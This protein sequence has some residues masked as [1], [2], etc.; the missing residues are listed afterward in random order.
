MASYALVDINNFY[1]SAERVFNPKLN[2]VPTTAVSNNDG[3]CISRSNEAKAPPY[4][5]KMGE[6]LFKIIQRFKPGEI[7]IVSSNYALYADLSDRVAHI[8]SMFSSSYEVYSVDEMFLD[9]TGLERMGLTH[10]GYE[11]KDTILKWT[12]LPVCVGIAATKTM[13]KL[14]NRVAKKRPEFNGVCNFKEMSTKSVDDIMASLPVDE[15]WGIGH[16][17]STKLNQL[18]IRTVLDLKNAHTRTMREKFSVVVAKTISELRGESCIDLEEQPPAKQNIA[19]TRSFG[20]PATDL[21]SLKESVTLYTSQAAEK[22]RKQGSYA[23]SIT[24]FIQTSPF[25]NRPY[26]GNSQT[27]ALPSPSNDTRLLV[28]TALWILNRLYRPGHVYQK[29]GVMLND[30]VPAAGV[31]QDMF[32]GQAISTMKSEKVMAVLDAVNQRY[33]RQ[34]L[35]LASEGFKAPWQM[36]QEFKT[37]DYTCDWDGLIKAY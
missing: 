10:Y 16:R 7:H 27:V 19:S 34:T 14:S 9:W 15:V 35:K 24:V 3:C 26:Y 12:G 23:N 1:V 32:F 20:I 28:R 22:A 37:P 29:S 17:L 6:P 25:A 18:G 13:A 11:L 30:L 5:I 21:S 36:K 2:G 8:V 31:Q 4:N 33:G